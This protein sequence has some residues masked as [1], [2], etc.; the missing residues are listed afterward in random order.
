MRAFNPSSTSAHEAVDVAVSFIPHAG[1]KAAVGGQTMPAL[2][3]AR[4]TTEAM[5]KLRM[6]I[7]VAYQTK[8]LFV[9]R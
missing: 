3:V 7:C 1:P 4:E 2:A 6:I 5:S 8:Q 9:M